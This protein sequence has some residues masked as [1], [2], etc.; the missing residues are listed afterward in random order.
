MQQPLGIF[1]V[2]QNDDAAIVQIA[3]RPAVLR[4]QAAIGDAPND[5]RFAL[6][7]QLP[8]GMKHR[9]PDTPVIAGDV[10]ATASRNEVG[11]GP[12]PRI[13]RV[14]RRVK[15]RHAISEANGG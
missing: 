14:A 1:V 10:G 7:A 15:R 3:R 9:G 13:K 2:T 11:I 6:L 12:E 5:V 4:R 8:V